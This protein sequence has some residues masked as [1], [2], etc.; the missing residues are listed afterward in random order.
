MGAS[1][2]PSE[3]SPSKYAPAR[4][5]GLG[6]NTDTKLLIYQLFQKGRV[7]PQD[8]H[9]RQPYHALSTAFVHNVAQAGRYHRRV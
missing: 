6:A 2:G 8:A 1:S 9:G 7:L 4:R 3:T 5:L